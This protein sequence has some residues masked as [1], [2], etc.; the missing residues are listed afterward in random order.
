MLKL[1]DCSTAP[2]P[3]RA[4]MFLAEKGLEWESAEVD[5]R[6]G[7]QLGEAFLKVNPA[8]TVPVLETE[9]GHRIT[10]NIGIAAYLDAA[11]PEPPLMGTTPLERAEVLSWNSRIEMGGLMAIA[12]GLRNSSPHMKGRALPGRRNIEQIPA[13]AERGRERLGWFF[14]SME[15][16]MAGRDFVATDRFTLA[17]ITMIVVFDFAR[18]VKGQPGADHPAL[19][20]YME[21]MRERPS[22]GL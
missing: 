1:Y 16:H 14:G 15:R 4:R 3:R 13:L 18:A 19:T 9:D 10:E 8:A 17:D 12:E 22:Y 7:E 5:L 20:A 11:Y 2:S 6:T 21:R